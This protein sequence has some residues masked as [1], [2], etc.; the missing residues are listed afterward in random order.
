MDTKYDF[1]AP[2][3]QD[4]TPQRPI[5]YVRSVAVKDLPREI[6]EQA[7][8]A[9]ELYAVHT[10]D[11]KRLALVRNRNLAFMLARQNDLS[12]VNVH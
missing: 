1:D 2:E 7:M 12:P 4:E 8:G 5:V 9:E 6:R 11:G 3:A 10:E